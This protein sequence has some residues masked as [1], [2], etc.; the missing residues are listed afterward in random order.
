MNDILI[1]GGGGHAKVVAALLKKHKDWNPI[2]YT[3]S[4]DRGPLLGLPYLG[5]DNVIL[6]L[7][8]GKGLKHA[9]IGIGLVGSSEH[10]AGVI[11]KIQAVRL[12]LPTICS[13]NAT[14]NEDVQIGDG[15]I[16]MDGV[17]IQP[18]VRIGSNSIVN[19][20]AILDHDCTIGDHVHIAPGVTLSGAVCLGNHILVGT[21][22]GIL[23][24]TKISDDVVIGGGAMVISDLETSGTYVG[25]PARL[26]AL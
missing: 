19:T 4:E 22:A 8:S 25:V 3:D 1:I 15:T 12:A 23:Q 17:V 6:A 7:I 5:T 20:G 26:K 16:V 10:R 11:R 14:I 24:G 2:G 9:V 18:G 13:P 21:A